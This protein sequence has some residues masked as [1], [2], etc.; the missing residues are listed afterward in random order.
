M[1]SVWLRTP[2]RYNEMLVVPLNT[3]AAWCQL[4]SLYVPRLRTKLLPGL[5]TLPR[6]MP[7]PILPSLS[8]QMARL[9]RVPTPV[10]ASVK[11]MIAPPRS[12][13]VLN[14]TDSVN[15]AVGVTGAEDVTKPSTPLVVMAALS[16][17]TPGWPVATPPTMLPVLLLPVL[18]ATR[19]GRVVEP[20]VR[21][22]ADG[23]DHRRV[24]R[25]VLPPDGDRQARR[26]EDRCRGPV[27]RGQLVRVGGPGSEA[28][29]LEAV[30]RAR[31]GPGLAGLGR[32]RTRAAI[33][34]EVERDLAVVVVPHAFGT[35]LERAGGGGSD[36]AEWSAPRV[37][38]S[39]RSA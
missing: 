13:V 29:V 39:R 30:N 3:A 23:V 12:V 18:S 14:H 25:R 20:P 32:D 2:S 35:D 19:A 26:P 17:A 11:P 22:R 9:S 4:P 36:A 15:A 27:T 7:K 21:G 38:R 34:V 37:P 31:L 24:D 8:I 5:A 33:A 10:W 28:G 6:R 1:F 16:N